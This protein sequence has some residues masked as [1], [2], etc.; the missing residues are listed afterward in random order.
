[1]MPPTALKYISTIFKLWRK[2]RH[3][4]LTRGNTCQYLNQNAKTSPILSDKRGLSPIPSLRASAL[5]VDPSDCKV[6][7]PS[8]I[9]KESN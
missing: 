8:N 9:V 2:W 6:L 4:I 5:K 3:E 1:M 7:R